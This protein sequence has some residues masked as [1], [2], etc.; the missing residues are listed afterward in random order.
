MPV[1]EAVAAAFGVVAVVAS[2][3]LAD[4]FGWGEKDFLQINQWA[5]EAAFCDPET[6][7]R[8]RKEFA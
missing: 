1:I 4:A 3:R 7:D 6:R 5:A 2:G 8:L